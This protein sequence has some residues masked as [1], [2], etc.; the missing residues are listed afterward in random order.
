MLTTISKRVIWYL[1]LT[2]NMSLFSCLTIKH[3][4]IGRE[5][6]T[7]FG[8]YL[9]AFLWMGQ[10]AYLSLIYYLIRDYRPWIFLQCLPLTNLYLCKTL[11]HQ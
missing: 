2:I 5:N 4:W 11:N 9:S 6:L 7:M 3:Q 8:I 10:M 1:W